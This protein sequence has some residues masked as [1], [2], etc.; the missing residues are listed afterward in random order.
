MI[1]SPIAND[2]ITNKQ[3]TGKASIYHT[4]RSVLNA[5]TFVEGFEVFFSDS[6]QDNSLT[7]PHSND[8]LTKLWHICR[9]GNSLCFLY[10]I[11]KPEQ[12]I[13]TANKNNNSAANKSKACVYHFIIACRDQLLFSEDSLFTVTELYQNDTNGFVKV[14]NTVKRILDL[15]E[16]KGTISVKSIKESALTTDSPK[17]MRDN[18]VFELLSTERKYVQDLE[19][20]QNYMR[21]VQA[22][23][24]LSPDTMHYLFGNLN[25]L[26]DFQRRFLIQIEDQASCASKDQRF[27][28]L[29]VQFEDAFSVYEPFCANFQIAQDLVVQESPKLQKLAHIMSPMYELPSMLIK[30]IQRVCKYPLLIGQLVKSTP[31]DWYWSHEN[32]QGLE[33]IQRV[34]KKVNETKRLQE[35][36]LVVQDLKKR[37][38]DDAGPILVETFG[39]LLLHEKF[40]LQRHDTDHSREM[41]VFLFQKVILVC[42]EIKDVNKN[43]ISIKKKRKE[44]SLVVRGKIFIT[45]I[46]HVKG[47][48]SQNGHYTLHISWTETD[49]QTVLLKCRNDEQLRQWLSVIIEVK[50]SATKIDLI[51]TPQTPRMDNNNPLLHYDEDEE[52]CFDDHEEEGDEY[53][54][55]SYHMYRGNEVSSRKASLSSQSSSSTTARHFMNGVP[56]M[57]LPPLPR[58]PTSIPALSNASVSTFHSTDTTLYS[59]SYPS[60]PPGSHPSSPTR[61]N[62]GIQPSGE[63]WQRRQGEKEEK[64]IHHVRARSQS[65]P[66]IQRPIPPAHGTAPDLPTN[67]TYK[68]KSNGYRYEVTAPPTPSPLPGEITKVKVHYFGAIYVVVVPTDIEYDDLQRRI[69]SKIK[70]CGQEF[71]TSILGLKYEDEDGDLITISSSEDVQMGFENKG[72]NNAVNLYVT[73]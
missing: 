72:P 49:T 12:P 16:E 50:E 51:S 66:N 71:E 20:L 47:S 19:G 23:E 56:G 7:L 39:D 64:K 14:V 44:G 34:T 2:S 11:L 17:D 65:S 30:P 27:G 61:P 48:S 15:L 8:P 38:V 59:P 13:M 63:L 42:K 24:I 53:S 36:T 68:R 46:E 3:A 33:A 4:C 28:S 57:T 40:T 60:S 29:F 73:S 26:V 69:E 41:V 10:N 9:Q 1:E 37:I 67:S 21:E 43:S 58:S 70:L 45:R 18:V 22:Q 54:R 52:D 32:K 5:L 25:A 62:H 35:N 55:K 31:E 6:N